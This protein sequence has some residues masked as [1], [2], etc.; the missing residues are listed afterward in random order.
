MGR[1][2]KIISIVGVV[3]IAVVVAGVA[4]LKSID[5]N[6][7][8]GLIAEQV[9]DA[10]GRDLV[11][12][13]DLNLELS[14]NPAVAVEGVSFSNAEWGSQKEMMTVKRFAA[15]V[16]LM[17]L[18]S[19]QVVVKRVILEGVELIAET[20]KKG[21]GNWEFGG[22]PKTEEQPA[23]A[24][25][26]TLP[27]VHSVRVRDLKVTYKDG[28]TGEQYSLG[29]DTVDLK[30]DG[31]DS[32]LMLNVA[33]NIN[34]EAFSVD[35]Q[36]GSL[37]AIA[38]GD[39]FP[40]K[41]D[42]AALATKIGLD[43]KAGTPGGVPKADIGVSLTAAQITDTLAAL[44]R[45]APAAKGIELPVTGA[46][47][48]KTR[49]GLDGPQKV[50]LADLDVS[51]GQLALKGR[52]SANLS[53]KVPEIDAA[54]NV[55]TLN[56]DE[57]LPKAK[58][59]AA[60]APAKASTDGRVFPGDPLPLDGL[61]AVNAKIKFDAKKIIVQKM[62]ITNTTVTIN[63]KDGNLSVK[64][65]SAMVAGGKIDGDVNLDGSRSTPS[66]KA[67]INVKQLDYGIALASQGMDDIAEG[68]VDVIV[69][70]TGAGK[71]VRQLMASLNGKSRIVTQ[72]GELKSG[73]LNIISTD[74]VNVFD[75]NDD[76]KIICGVVD[77]DIT[78]GQAAA[79]AIVVETGGFS[80]VG[81]GGANLA[82]E[83]L[84]LRVDPR[85]KKTNLATVAMV[86]VDV[87]GTFAK[88]EW[89]IDAAAMAGNVAAGAA[90]TGTAIAT[91]GL[92]LLV[93]KAVS[94]AVKSVDNTDYCTPALAGKKVV[95]GKMAAAEEPKKSGTTTSTTSAPAPA[96]KK[97][98]GILGGVGSG[99]KS[100]FSN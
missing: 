66:L 95:P 90:R 18:L 16:S 81:T 52:L 62:D 67:K 73:A 26:A 80:V 42:I 46:L 82:D 39:M 13:G 76:K 37:A 20:D 41:L 32:P 84:K 8:K 69:N 11:I 65:L 51:L 29:V 50:S 24:S 58:D 30:S 64:P 10:T 36:V 1:G 89:A 5:F 47:S 72:N 96:E 70:V 61:K 44:G 78:K 35:G 40:L 88:P 55:D 57:L 22:A 59:G 4:I 31:G 19:S 49:L 93:E 94:S 91:M 71:S 9:K 97:E 25:E 54:F 33:G 15:E 6:E 56:L 74:L 86:P 77:F 12:N 27:V 28:V 7:Y 53:G 17:P 60:P 34:G 68:K 63:L 98:E 23:E 14:L 99:L 87:T 38:G 43:G 79:R 85:A 83:T 48:V 45:L 100:L 3:L 2:I 21:R 92:S 75:S